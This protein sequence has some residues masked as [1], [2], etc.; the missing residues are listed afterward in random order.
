MRRTLIAAALSAL[1]A[2][3]QAALAK[4][5]ARPG[6]PTQDAGVP[7][8]DRAG[9]YKVFGDGKRPPIYN[10]PNI[11][12]GKWEKDGMKIA[13]RGKVKVIMAY[14]DR[15][16]AA[17]QRR[18]FE[19]ANPFTLK[20]NVYTWVV[21]ENGITSF[22]NPLDSWEVGTRHAHLSGGR[23]VVAS[24]E[25]V[26]GNAGIRLNMLSGTYMI[27]LVKAGTIDPAKYGVRIKAWFDKVLRKKY[28]GAP[29]FKIEFNQHGK[30]TFH[31]EA[32]F[33]TERSKGKPRLPDP[34]LCHMKNTTKL[35]DAK[36]KFA[37][38][39]VDLCKQVT[40]A[41]CEGAK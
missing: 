31:N 9:V 10:P 32:I 12:G 38:L 4:G 5:P 35:C 27:P 14:G 20:N 7:N 6:K 3:T 22:G 36:F 26:K 1:F 40:A 17:S 21:L 23:P 34:S 39:N 33:E 13:G 29:S 37:A 2:F 25:L 11:K 15:A 28:R 8:A 18:V 24:G 19:S 16:I 30:S 41:K